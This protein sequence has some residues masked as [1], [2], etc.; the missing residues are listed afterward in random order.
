VNGHERNTL[1]CDLYLHCNKNMPSYG[2]T[3]RVLH[4]RWAGAGSHSPYMRSLT[5]ISYGG[6]SRYS[7]WREN[8]IFQPHRQINKHSRQNTVT[9]RTKTTRR[10]RYAEKLVGRCRAERLTPVAVRNAGYEARQPRCRLAHQPHNASSLFPNITT[11]TS[12]PLLFFS[13]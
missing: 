10:S 2:V 3:V 6:A 8:S 5:L 11:S 12:T 13:K 7:L 4:S 9:D 1:S